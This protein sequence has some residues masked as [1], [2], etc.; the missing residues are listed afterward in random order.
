MA[1]ARV[2]AEVEEESKNATE[3]LCNSLLT[4]NAKNQFK[5]NGSVELFESVL[6]QNLG[7]SADVV[8]KFSNGTC[9]VWKAPSVTFNLYTKTKTLLVQGKAVDY[10]RDLLLQ[11]I[12]AANN[13]SS[14]ESP[15]ETNKI[16]FAIEHTTGEAH[17]QVG[18]LSPTAIAD[19]RNDH[20][21]VREDPEAALGEYASNSES[22][23]EFSEHIQLGLNTS[24]SE[25]LINNLAV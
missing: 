20:P 15:D 9:T 11:T 23:G 17:Q 14:A 13:P 2:L 10:T 6:H 18:S 21:L 16:H 8:T 24:A 12:Q 19:T 4:V 25:E 7:L 22:E 1:D 3:E 5:W